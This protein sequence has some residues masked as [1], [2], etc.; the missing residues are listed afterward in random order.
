MNPITVIKEKVADLPKSQRKVADYIMNN[1][2]EVAFLTLDQ[3]AHLIGTST[4]T[5]MRFTFNLGYSGYSEFQKNL[6]ELLRNQSAPQTRLEINIKEINNSELWERFAETQIQNIKY[7]LGSISED[8]LNEFIEM[9][10]QS[11]RV[12]CTCVR[13]G[14]PVAQYLTQGINRL[15]GNC[16]LIIADY[17]D[18]AD[19]SV[20][21]NS[22]DLLIAV[23]YP[24]YANRI[25]DYVRIANNSNCKIISITDSYSSPLIKYSDLVIRT[26]PESFAFHNSPVT[27]MIIVDYIISA[28]AIKYPERTKER[29]DKINSILLSMNY[30]HEK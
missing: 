25:V 9:I 1:Q 6:Q 12:F 29:L 2:M 24:R 23:S 22:E 19:K 27:A 8:T 10:I 16:E 30:H 4:T 14:L 5:V 15:I 21:L 18:W 20:D 11:K 28:I 13:S 7:T 26:S 17:S 3:L